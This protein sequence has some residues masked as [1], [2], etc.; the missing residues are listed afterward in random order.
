MPI[1]RASYQTFP[2]HLYHY[3]HGDAALSII[4]GSAEVDKEICFWLK[5]AR[6]KNDAA[7]LKLGAALTEGLQ[8]YMRDHNRSSI[9]NEIE[10]NPDLVFINS[11]TEG[12]DVT[13]HLLTEYGNFRLEF[14]LRAC[15]C[16]NDI[17]EC[18]YFKEEE[19]EELTECYCST[20]DR[21]WPL[22]SGEKKDIGALVEYL[23]EGMSAVMSIPLLKHMDEWEKEREWRHVL[24]RQT[25]DERVFTH[26]DG[27]PRMKV[28]YPASSLT[29]ITYF[30]LPQN[31][32]SD[33]D[34]YRAIC[35]WVQ[36]QGWDAQVKEVDVYCEGKRR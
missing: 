29:G 2:K 17:R 9:L 6:S 7:E 5:N 27:L 13:S 18:T 36:K 24:H 23:E 10:I 20:F 25:E 22:I 28:F 4:S 14:D 19:I 8:N 31:K 34:Y 33:K 3:T 32:E 30:P 21:C 11:F 15:K 1:V 26:P 12:E 16:K 35:D